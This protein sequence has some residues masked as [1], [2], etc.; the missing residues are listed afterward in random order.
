[1]EVAQGS[2]GL[3]LLW[4]GPPPALGSG[5]SDIGLGGRPTL[6]NRNRGA[7]KCVVVVVCCNVN[8]LAATDGQSSPSPPSP[9]SGTAWLTGRT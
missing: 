2:C 8:H 9:V 3:A 1:V 6:P 4:K 5:R 7:C